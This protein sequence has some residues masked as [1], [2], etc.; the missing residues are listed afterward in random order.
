MRVSGQ[1]EE[2]A[3]VWIERNIEKKKERKAVREQIV[4][5]CFDSP[6]EREKVKRS[7]REK[8][9]RNHFPELSTSREIKEKK[10]MAALTAR[11]SLP[12]FVPC[13]IRKARSRSRPHSQTAR[14]A[15]ERPEKLPFP[16]PTLLDAAPLARRPPPLPWP[17]AVSLD[18]EFSHYQEEP[19]D[20]EKGEDKRPVVLR[21]PADVAVVSDE[22]K[23]L[24]RALVSPPAAVV[25]GEATAAAAAAKATAAASKAK[26]KTA[27]YRWVGGVPRDET[28]SPQALPLEPVAKELARLLSKGC[29]LVGHGVRGDLRALGG[30]VL[31]V[32]SSSPSPSPSPSLSSLSIPA[33]RVRD[34]STIPGLLKRRKNGRKTSSS[35]KLD[36]LFARTFGLE[37]RGGGGGGSGAAAAAAAA[38]AERF[39][40]PS[41]PSSLP[42]RHDPVADAAAAMA[43]YL[44]LVRGTL[45]DAASG[46]ELEEMETER[47]LLD[48]RAR[49]R[50]RNER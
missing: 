49:E 17:R 40:D 5:A 39:P 19:D 7:L 29:L 43:L 28:E 21:V 23:V 36:E 3:E 31:V 46:A 26:A 24:L 38:A 44:T 22:G 4:F 2:R 10:T 48:F 6:S 34:T 12:Q 14:A 32:S 13:S 15:N 45:E 47:V 20:G 16:M 11:L 1:G 8:K 41:S 18:V 42:A 9:K 35:A 37:L 30:E 25:G 33:S 50:S 27:P